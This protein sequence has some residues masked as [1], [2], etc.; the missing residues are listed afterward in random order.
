MRS[1]TALQQARSAL[2]NANSLPL[3]GQVAKKAQNGAWH[4]A[5]VRV[6]FTVEVIDNGHH[7]TTKST[8]GRGS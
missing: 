7:S 5:A 2:L 3:T 1:N 8:R 4:Q 6:G